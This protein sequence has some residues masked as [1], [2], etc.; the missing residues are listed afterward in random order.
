MFNN[1]KS[2]L[3]CFV[4]LFFSPFLTLFLFI[5]HK[6]IKENFFIVIIIVIYPAIH[7]QRILPSFSSHEPK[8]WHGFDKHKN[9][10]HSSI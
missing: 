8:F 5:K 1:R 3:L 7:L 4:I 2:C 10:M 9:D 6:Q